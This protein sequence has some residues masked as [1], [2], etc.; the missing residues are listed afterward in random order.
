MPSSLLFAGLV[1]I[2]LV[3]LVPMAARRRAQMPRPSEAALSCRVLD[4]PRRRN[5]EVSTVEDTQPGPAPAEREAPDLA[6]PGERRGLSQR[7]FRPGRGGFDAAAAALAARDRHVFR[8]RAV[9]GL[10]VLA[11]ASGLFAW[12]LGLGWAWFFH[13]GVDLC[14]VGYLAYL[15]QQVRIEQSIR[16][17]RAARMAGSRRTVADAVADIGDGERA[18]EPERATTERATA[19]SDDAERDAERDDAEQAS[20]DVVSDDERSALPPMPPLPPP[21]RPVG[22][23]VVELDDE[24]PT[25][26]ELGD[27]RSRS[28]RRASG[29]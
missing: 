13:V 9:L 25:L 14:L 23:V 20:D 10:A 18:D 17:R 7:R 4:R 6:D 22:T 1:L 26:H 15:R 8:Q 3:V 19:E 2:W 28:Y 21:R 5:Q 27:T 29:Q 24:D 12:A 11:L 16:A